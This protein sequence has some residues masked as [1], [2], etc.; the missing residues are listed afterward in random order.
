M[1][2]RR[3]RQRA[4]S[5]P[6]GRWQPEWPEH[7]VVKECLGE[8]YGGHLSCQAWG[9]MLQGSRCPPPLPMVSRGLSPVLH[10][11][12]RGKEQMKG[13]WGSK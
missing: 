12:N 4:R 8:E 10:G 2:K 3:R 1:G 5:H 9:G 7:S 13:G 6:R 11:P